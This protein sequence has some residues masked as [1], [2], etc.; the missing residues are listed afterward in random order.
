MGMPLSG[1]CWRRK[2]EREGRISGILWRLLE[3]RWDP[4]PS[5]KRKRYIVSSLVMRPFT[6][7]S[8]NCLANAPKK[9]VFVFPA[10][11]TE[12]IVSLPCIC[13]Y[14]W[15]KDIWVLRNYI[16]CSSLCAPLPHVQYVWVISLIVSEVFAKSSVISP[17]PWWVFKCRMLETCMISHIMAITRDCA[18]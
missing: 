18:H 2:S 1:C 16:F 8:I 4:F 3:S 15:R 6:D 11:Y 9:C 17:C 13:T 7:T 10:T 14:L 12:I 5:L